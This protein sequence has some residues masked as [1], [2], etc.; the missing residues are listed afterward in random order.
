MA[1]VPRAWLASERR[2]T[3]R[4][5]VLECTVWAA[6]VCVDPNALSVAPRAAT[7]CVPASALSAE[8]HD[9][10]IARPGVGGPLSGAGCAVPWR[11]LPFARASARRLRAAAQW[12]RY[13]VPQE[14][15]VYRVACAP[16][17]T[18]VAAWPLIRAW[19]KPPHTS[20]WYSSD[21]AKA[22][23]FMHSV[24]KLRYSLSCSCGMRPICT[25]NFMQTSAS[26]SSRMDC[27]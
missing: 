11:R 20:V 27:R 17:D 21:S 12:I 19:R 4:A 10:G 6:A 7:G 25:A 9:R 16:C 13:R 14:R 23:G 8:P 3:L 15:G 24:W 26:A 2:Q 18:L 5:K 1:A 22:G